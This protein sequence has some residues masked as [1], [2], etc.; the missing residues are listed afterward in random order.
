MPT[1]EGYRMPRVP[2]R[3]RQSLNEAAKRTAWDGTGVEI[4]F[5]FKDGC[6]K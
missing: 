2:E 1:P 3:L 5:K 6:E 4:R